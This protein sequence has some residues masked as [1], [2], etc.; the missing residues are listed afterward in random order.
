M[1]ESFILVYLDLIGYSKNN[2]PIQVSLFKNFQKTIHK[3]L[4]EETLEADSIFIPTGDGIIAGI[5][6]RD[7][8]TSY[9][10]A[11]ELIVGVAEWTRSNNCDVRCSIHVGDVNIIKDVNRHDNIVGNTINDAARI[12]S[13]ANDGGIVI[14]KTFYEKFLRKS[15]MSLG[16]RYKIS[17]RWYFAL[18]DEDV[19]LDKHSFEHNI[20]NLVLYCDHKIYGTGDKILSKF[21]T[22]IYS[23]DYP[24]SKNLR[25]QFL[26]R[27]EIGSDLD[28]VGIYH[29]S[30]PRIL[31]NIKFP[32]DRKVSITIYYAADG[33]ADKIADFFGSDTGNLSFEN[34]ASSINQ[35]KEWYEKH[36]FRSSIKLSLLEY[37]ELL[38]F[39]LSMVDKGYSGKGFIHVSHYLPKIIPAETPYIEMEWRTNNMPPIYNFYHSYYAAFSHGEYQEIRKIR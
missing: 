15:G 5:R 11:F 33:L 34:K 24:K 27:V 36:E 22:N 10:Q 28:F 20:Y 26:G 18:T 17:D 25:E 39:G 7:V 4:Y 6:N 14:S 21:Y 38:P 29:P 2:E 1:T 16:Y 31:G 35:V 9:L 37:T 19:V 3:L 23:T 30:L 12:L 13:G 8:S 32:F